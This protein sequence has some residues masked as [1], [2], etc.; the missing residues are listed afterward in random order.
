MKQLKENDSK[1]QN[2][3]DWLSNMEQ[4]PSSDQKGK[5]TLQQNGNTI[6]VDG[7]QVL[8]NEDTV[9]GNLP[10]NVGETMGEEEKELTTDGDLHGQYEKAKVGNECQQL[11]I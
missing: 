11:V 1:I 8:E 5:E 2:L 4:E 7:L 10:C 9:N 3:L 6:T